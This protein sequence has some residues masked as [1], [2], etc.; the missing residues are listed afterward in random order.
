MRV[1]ANYIHSSLDL[2]WEKVVCFNSSWLH[3]TAQARTVLCSSR[4]NTSSASSC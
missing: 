4:Q 1:S 2:P 3:R